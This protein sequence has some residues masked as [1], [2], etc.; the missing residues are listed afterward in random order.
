MT[1]VDSWTTSEELASLV[2]RDRGIADCSGWTVSLSASGAG[3]PAGGPRTLEPGVTESSGHDYVFDLIS[4]LELAPSFPACRSSF[5]VS[6]DKPKRTSS[7]KVHLLL[8]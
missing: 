7:S 8:I 3:D 2:I 5:L 6:P 4:E 1:P